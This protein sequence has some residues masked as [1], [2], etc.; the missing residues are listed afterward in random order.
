ML[1]V[2]EVIGTVAHE[3]GEGM[4]W[5]KK[6]K[7]VLNSCIKNRNNCFFCIYLAYFKEEKQYS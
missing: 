2:Q 7:T 6:K 1:A 3:L 5:F 4:P